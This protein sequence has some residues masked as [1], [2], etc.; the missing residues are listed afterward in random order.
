MFDRCLKVGLMGFILC[1]T[2]LGCEAKVELPALVSDGMVLQRDQ[3]ISVWGFARPGEKVSV[4]FLNKTYHADTDESGNWKITLPP[5]KAGGPYIMK[6]NDI[7]LKDILIGDVWLCSGQSNMELQ[8]SRVGD[9]FREEI[10]TYS[11]PM[12][13]HIKIPLHYNFHQPEADVNPASWK[14]LTPDNAP[15]FSATAYFFAKDLYDKIKIPIGLINSSVGGSP[16][17]AWISAEK[18]KSFPACYNDMMICRSDE[19]V[20][21]V[22]ALDR[23]RRD[24]W[25]AVL[26]SRD[27]GLNAGTK[28]YSPDYDDESW[29]TIDLFDN[30]WGKD[31][32]NPINGSFWFRKKVEIPESLAGKQAVLRLGCIVDA[33]SVYVNGV[34]VGSVSYRYPPRIYPIPEGLLKKGGNVITVRLM[35]YSGYPEFVEDKPY[36]MIIDN[37]E[38]DLTGKWK[39]KCGTEMPQLQGEVSF[40]YKPAGLYNAMIAPLLN[41]GFKGVLWYQ[42]ESNTGRY[43]EYYSLMS[44]LIA[45]WRHRLNQPDLPFFIVQLASFMKSY[46]YPTESNW[47]ELREVQLKLSQAVPNTGLAVTIDIGEWN[48]IHPLNKKEVG[49]RLSLLA[50]NIS[51]GYKN[52]ICNGPIYKSMTVEGGKIIL[53]FEEGTNDLQPVDELKG[54]TIAGLNKKFVNAKAIVTGNNVMVWSDDITQPVMVRYA[55]ADNP[56]GANLYNKEGLPASPFQTDDIVKK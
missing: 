52:V 39:W 9:M 27:Q 50:Q 49:K 12:I 43:N 29:N 13:R 47:A 23:K 45:D 44:T 41:A 24:L 25:N 34:F 16:A 33:D 51:Y 6:I 42:G 5:Q 31:G 1:F 26:Y 18:L 11:N 40:Q 3:D 48:D 55:W 32:L 19:Y 30:S 7:E 37:T 56:E 54:F 36:K 21:E 10:K 15:D 8:V 53:S 4:S 38:I 17:E 14:T 22:K 46:D 28:W 20:S 35:S 2:S